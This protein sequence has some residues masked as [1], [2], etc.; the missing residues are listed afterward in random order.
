YEVR[1]KLSLNGF[2]QSG[3]LVL[4]WGY[5][6]H[7]YDASTISGL[8]MKFIEGLEEL[9]THC[10]DQQKEGAVYTP[11]DYGLG[12]E[13]SYAELDAFLE[14]PFEGKKRK[15]QIEGIYRLSG[16]QQGILFHGLYDTSGIGVYIDQFGCDLL[17]VDLELFRL[18]WDYVLTNH[19]ILRSAFYADTF[20]A[21]VQSAYSNVKPSITILDYRDL[22]ESEQL[23][24]FKEYEEAD[25]IKGFDFKVP[26]L[27]RFAL[28]R[29]TDDRWRML[30]TWHHILLDGWSKPLLIEEFLTAYEVFATG[31]EPALREDDRYEDFIRYIERSNKEQE[32]KYW[33]GYMKGVEQSTLLPFI[34][35]TPER[36]K[37]I[38]KSKMLYLDISESLTTNIQ[39]YAQQNK[40]TANTIM[41]GVWSVLLHRYTG[42]KDIVF[43]IIVSGRPDDLPRVEQRVGMYINT[44]P[45]HTVINKEKGIVDWLQQIQE[46]QLSSRQY[47]HTPFSNIQSWSGVQGDIFDSILVFQNYPFSKVIAS[48]PWKLKVENIFKHEQNNLPLTVTVSVAGQMSIEFRYNTGLLSEENVK[49]IL[50]HFEEAIHQLISNP[51]GTVGEIELLTQKEQHQLVRGFNDSH[52]SYPAEKSVVDLFEEQAAKT[53]GNAAIVFEEE[54]LS[55]QQL[56]E[57]SNQLARYLQSRGVVAETLVPICMERGLDMMVGILGILK[58]GGAY[59]PIDTSFPPDRVNYML[60]DTGSAL[61]LTSREKSADFALEQSTDIIEIDGDWS[62]VKEYSTANLQ[63][64]VPANH[65]AYVIY[66]SGSTGKPKGVM[67]EH[68]N[69]LDYVAGLE[70]NLQI[71]QCRSFAL[72]STI[73][74]DLGNT[75]I[76]GSLLTGGC[77]HIFSRESVSDAELLHRYFRKHSIDC[78]K[79]VPSHWKALS[80]EDRL[81]LPSKLLVFGG[82]AL[83]SG[84]VEEIR[85]S[86]TACR[87][88]NHYGPTETTIGK[89]LHIVEAGRV[90]GH[91][92]PI[93]KP[94][95]N[96]QTYILSGDL[97]LCPVGVPG[98]LYIAGE[99]V[100][101]GYFNNIELTASKF[102]PDPFSQDTNSKMYGT[103]DL[104]KYLGD[105][106]I[107]FI[108]RVDDQVKIRGYRIELGEIESIL[109]QCEMVSHAVVLAREDKQGNR[110][111]VGYIVAAGWFDREGILSYLKEQV[112]E[113]MVPAILVELESLP[114]TANGKI[115]RKAL[116]DPDI[117][118][119]LSGQYVAPRTEM[120]IKL[121]EIWQEVLE[122]DRVG[123]HDNFFD[124]GGHSLLAVRLISMVRKELEIELA[125][126]TFFDLPTIEEL[127]NYIKLTKNNYQVE[128]EEY[129]TFKL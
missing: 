121:A 10:M 43:G 51:R 35:K 59:V 18:S 45:L 38:G 72:V 95:S 57:R 91:T 58:A 55:Y 17:N 8:A 89:L 122:V 7:H 79:I 36:M 20:S 109:Q 74:T 42:N 30:W 2:V 66:T 49:E 48:Q 116:P 61:L 33:R 4:N 40:V 15:E 99:G 77:L 104:V 70:Q 19:S 96:T 16:L 14:E 75:V 98:Q 26:P 65:L 44:M 85:L 107:E 86:G 52:V 100:A 27:M 69:L 62:R 127:A 56:N 31:K 110:R 54:Q 113:Y 83:Q 120:E 73:A 32:E 93:G 106:N 67:I 5:S 118:E 111:L 1:E 117:A 71:G 63:E 124:L 12:A 41:Q 103:G 108:G 112:P 115:D 105:G 119:G 81:L 34:G 46:E 123:I 21:P 39:N 13:M 78:L 126:N 102:I 24:A 37:E 80:L 94:F 23:V 29:L 11:S 88:V 128:L 101:R 84:L 90:Y 87:V 53:P 47:Q 25:V 97:K 28:I 114:L 68:R 92:I 6:S 50:G 82:E 60:Q 125:I 9:I 129:D 22:N 3:E 64:R 76:Y